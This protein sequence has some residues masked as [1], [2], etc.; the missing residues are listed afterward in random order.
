MLTRRKHGTQTEVLAAVIH[1]F[2][3]VAA[4]RISVRSSAFTRVQRSER[5]LKSRGC[6]REAG[7]AGGLSNPPEGGTPNEKLTRTPPPESAF[8][9]LPSVRAY[10]D[11]KPRLCYTLVM[12][13]TLCVVLMS[14]GL[15]VGLA[16]CKTKPKEEQIWEQVKIGDLAPRD[17]LSAP[18]FS[19]IITMDVQILDLPADRVDR[20]KDVWPVLSANPIKL[21]SYNAFTG[22]SFRMRYGRTE[23]WPQIQSLLAEAGAQKAASISM[24]L[25]ANEASDLPIA[26]LPVGREISYVGSNLLKQTARVGSGILVL[27]L[28]AEPIPW[29]R[30]VHKIIGYPT[31]MIPATNTIAPLQAKARENEFY[32]EPA[33][34]A[35]Q[36]APGDL[37]VIGPDDYTGE[38]QTLGGLFFNKPD[39]TLFFNPAKRTPP[40]I[41]PSVRVYVLICS[42]IND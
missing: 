36:M 12:V 6:N 22:N 2:S 39:G 3:M 15:F 41:K 23:A 13:R 21:I 37:I 4:L 25:P 20:L 14:L 40:E 17:K 34:F 32:F 42:A 10:V 1:R 30:G 29:A 27:R 19:S 8:A 24:V 5:P 28:R 11:R 33:A 9:P 26:E 18:Q 38:R 35:V 31:Y 7:Y 16:G